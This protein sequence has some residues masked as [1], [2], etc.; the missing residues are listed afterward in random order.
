MQKCKMNHPLKD[1][2]HIYDFENEH[3]VMRFWTQTK[4]E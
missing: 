3:N 2:Q 1:E 4:D